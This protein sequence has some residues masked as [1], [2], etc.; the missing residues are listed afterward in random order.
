LR[1]P[2]GAKGKWASGVYLSHQRS[3]RWV[4][5]NVHCYELVK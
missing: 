4:R 3:Q 2:V 1:Q 5:R